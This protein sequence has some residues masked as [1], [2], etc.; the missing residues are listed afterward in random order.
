[1]GNDKTVW[2]VLV[3]EN[4]RVVLSLSLSLRIPEIPKKIIITLLTGRE[5]EG[6]N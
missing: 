5:W 1:M 6:E 4:G 3:C 2:R